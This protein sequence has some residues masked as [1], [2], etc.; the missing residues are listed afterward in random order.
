LTERARIALS[1][2]RAAY[3]SLLNVAEMVL[4][5][6]EAPSTRRADVAFIRTHYGE[7]D[8]ALLGVLN[9]SVVN[10]MH[11][12]V[13]MDEY[14]EGIL[15]LLAQDKLLTYPATSMSRSIHE[16]VLVLLRTFDLSLTTDER[17][18]RMVALDLKSLQGALNGFRAF[19]G[20]PGEDQ[21][22]IV[23][24]IEQLVTYL[25]AAGFE[26]HRKRSNPDLLTGLSWNGIREDLESDGTTTA[27][28]TY[29]PEIHFN[30]VIGSAATHSRHWYQQG[31]EG[32]TDSSV[33]ALVL[34]LLDLSRILVKHLGAYFGVEVGPFVSRTTMRI[35]MLLLRDPEE[36]LKGREPLAPSS[37]GRP[38]S[39]NPTHC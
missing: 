30:W 20:P 11:S 38:D 19:P 37:W 34:P 18:V 8:V 16:S 21:R 3:R 27:S 4:K 12:L 9:K 6:V 15:A 7:R 28:Q 23:T 22:R 39:P 10:A 33:Q 26:L 35:R 29:T 14:L 1:S 24:H 17:L 36:M 5:D 2:E 32:P 13:I 31:D 25:E